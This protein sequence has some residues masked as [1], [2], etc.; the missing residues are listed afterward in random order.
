LQPGPDCKRDGKKKTSQ[1]KSEFKKP[2]YRSPFTIGEIVHF[3]I[4][5]KIANSLPASAEVKKMSIYTSTP[6]YAF[7]A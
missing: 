1:A 7:M 3:Y 4:L 2:N 6:P 5:Q